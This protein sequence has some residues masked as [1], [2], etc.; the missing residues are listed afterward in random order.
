MANISYKGDEDNTCMVF[1]CNKKRHKLRLCLQH[2]A[3][4]YGPSIG[5]FEDAVEFL[6]WGMGEIY[7][8]SGD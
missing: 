3:Y 6:A 2:Y 1:G 4:H 7:G 8:Q 5:S